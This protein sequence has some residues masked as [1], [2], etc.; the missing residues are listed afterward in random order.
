MA[1]LELTFHS[2][3]LQKNVPVSILLP[4]N[5]KKAGPSGAPEGT[6]KTLYLL[7]G[8]AGCHSDWIRKTA[9]ERYADKHGIA[10]VMPGVDRSWYTDTAYGLNYFTFVAQEL[11]AVCRSYFKGMTDRREDN[12]IAGISMG[13]YGAMKVALT[14]PECYCG[15]ASLSGALDI[16][17]RGGRPYS[18]P[19][20]QSI[21]GFTMET[22]EELEGSQHDVFALAKQN[23]QKQAQFPKLYLWCGT[24]DKLI[25]YNRRFHTHLTDLN[26]DHCYEESDGDHTWDHWDKHFPT[27]L[28]YILDK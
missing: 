21:F 28:R 27:A 18:L 26:I 19:E 11:P 12:L 23:K 6:Y 7:H 16:T 8:L 3:A 13:G 5:R 4:E 24:E 9:I 2:N 15:C 10:V 1:F 14:Y 20:W 25:E 17:R 22:P